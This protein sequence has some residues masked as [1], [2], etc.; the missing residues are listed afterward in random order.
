MLYLTCTTITS[1]GL[2]H[3]GVSRVKD[4]V[5]GD[6]GTIPVKYA[7]KLICRRS[8]M[9]GCK[10]DASFKNLNAVLQ[11]KKKK[12]KKKKSKRQNQMP[13]RNLH[14]VGFKTNIKYI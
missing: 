1:V 7:S 4:W 6:C 2:A 3:Y 8:S 12:K 11:Q 13:M 10:N 14:F 9:M 5:S